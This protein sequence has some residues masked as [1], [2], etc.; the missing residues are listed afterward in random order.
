MVKTAV[1]AALLLTS[2][3]AS[4]QA[5]SFDQ[6]AQQAVATHPSVLAKQSS[7]AAAKADLDSASWQ[8]YPTPTLEF[9]NDNHGVNTTLFRLQQPLWAGGRIT[10]GINAA[11]SRHDAAATAIGETRQE[12][13]F[14]IIAAYVEAAREQERATIV[15]QGVEQHERLLGM[16]TRRVQQEASPQVDQG[17]AQSRL[18]QA[19]NDLSSVKQA[20]S[21]ALTQLSQL[22]GQPIGSVYALD[23]NGATGAGSK[24]GAIDQAIGASVVLERL[25]FE[26]AA[27]QAEVEAKKAGILPQLSLRYENARASA[28]LNGIPGYSTSRV[29]LVVE[30][31][32]GA[33]LSVL[34]GIEA[35]SARRDSIRLQRETAR[36]D[37]QERVAIDWDE[38]M[39]ARNRLEN[40]RLASS[41]AKEVSESYTRQYTAG[42]KTWLDVLNT[43]RESTQSDVA[44]VDAYAQVTGALLRLR[45]ETGNMPGLKR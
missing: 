12:L 36:R 42:R 27:A 32:T 17:L 13:L 2:P 5:W 39:A 4:A 9:G 6:I 15:A 19:T 11:S 38:W 33:G 45:L 18:Y 37:L 25:A 23:G 24:E 1:H 29:L 22:A 21:T 8:R 7:A 16:I 28:P 40:A 44:V 35:A 34:S 10:A 31:Q 41:N 26:E 30:S 3:V 20:L 43:I 14:R